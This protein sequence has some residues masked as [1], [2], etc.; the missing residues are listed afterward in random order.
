MRSDAAFCSRLIPSRRSAAHS[1]AV[2][3]A[4]VDGTD[5]GAAVGGLDGAGAALQAETARTPAA[6]R[7]SSPA[8]VLR[9]GIESTGR[10]P[11]GGSEAR[12]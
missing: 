2:G 9:M 5:E 12:G 11:N 10:V 6:T 3:G 7:A 1:A 4:D 8:R